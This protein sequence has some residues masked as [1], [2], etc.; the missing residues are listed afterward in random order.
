MIQCKKYNSLS[1]VYILCVRQLS[2]E[3]SA[4]K[5]SHKSNLIEEVDQLWYCRVVLTIWTASFSTTLQS[6]RTVLNRMQH[7]VVTISPE[8]K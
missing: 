8:S 5:I 7:N 6:V 2:V 1:R 3:G 4:R